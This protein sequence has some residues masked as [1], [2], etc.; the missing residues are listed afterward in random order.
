MSAISTTGARIVRSDNVHPGRRGHARRIEATKLES[1]SQ[2]QCLEAFI[3]SIS[4]P[5][6]LPDRFF[7]PY[8][9]RELVQCASNFSSGSFFAS[10]I[11]CITPIGVDAGATSA[12]FVE[13]A[14]MMVVPQI[15]TMAVTRA[16]AA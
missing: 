3:T 7:A 10:F 14:V 4:W 16:V 15:A 5:H 6:D 1:S 11:I 13:C 8:R 9:C 12:C 2:Y